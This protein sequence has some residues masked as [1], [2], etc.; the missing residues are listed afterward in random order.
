D[1]H[2]HGA[3]EPLLSVL[4]EPRDVELHDRAGPAVGRF[5]RI[6]VPIE[7]G[8]AVAEDGAAG[9][10]GAG[11]HGVVEPV[12]G[13]GRDGNGG[14]DGAERLGVG[15][16]DGGGHQVAREGKGKCRDCAGEVVRRSTAIRGATLAGGGGGD[17]MTWRGAPLAP[18]TRGC[19]HGWCR[20]W[21]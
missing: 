13:A 12:A 10:A 15:G 5:T 4:V 11:L 6:N 2:E 21:S 3:F 18:R 8:L 14:V 17:T 16:V 19:L 9:V 7:P 20:P 1:A